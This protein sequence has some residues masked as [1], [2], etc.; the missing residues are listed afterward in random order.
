M[1]L[2]GYA[3][4]MFRSELESA[5]G[6]EH[7]IGQEAIRKELAVDCY[8]LTHMWKEKN[9]DI[10][11][12]YFVVRPATTEQT[13]KVMRICNTYKVPV[14]P[15][16]GG[17]GTQGG[18]AAMYGGILLELT[19]MNQVIGI[20]EESLIL[21][22]QP[23]ING[24]VLENM[25]NEKGLM[26]AHY[27]SSV[28]M[29]TLGGYLAARGSGVMSTK[30][31]KA[32]DMVLSVEMVLPDGKIINTLSLP[33]HACGPGLL[34]LFVGS[35]GTLGVITKVSIRLDPLPETRLFRMFKFPSVNAGLE[36]GRE[37]MIKRLNPAVMRLYDPGSTKKSLKD[38][39]QPLEGVNMVL[40]VD[41]FKELAEVHMSKLI[42]ICTSND[43]IDLGHEPGVYWWEHRYD[44]YKPPL[45]PA[46][47]LLYGTVESITTYANIKKLYEEKKQLVEQKYK[48][49]NATYMAHF[50]HWYPWGTMIYDRFYIENPPE[51]AEEAFRLHNQIWEECSRVNMKNGALLNEHHGIGFKL[52]WLMREQYGDA[53][54]VL[55]D[56]KK[57]IDPKGIMNP[58]KLGFGIW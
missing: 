27:P 55:L 34:Q 58:G 32:E 3:L 51:D 50:S 42:D 41:G 46:Y 24:R 54:D 22:A 20:D 26:L 15:R 8:W 23:G 13:S 49:W 35:E 2:T 44:F 12:P 38:T 5:V 1:N 40:M 31:G 47:P 56:I 10:Q 9:R 17:S 37:I 18:A 33:N 29:A 16:G 36:A 43:G 48:R 14:V 25:L 53:F 57:A 28:D 11:L 6:V 45:Q 30:Y 52:G 7:V 4:E 39:G 21:T 19:R